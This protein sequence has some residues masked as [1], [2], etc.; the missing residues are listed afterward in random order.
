MNPGPNYEEI[1][2]EGSQCRGITGYDLGQ[3]QFSEGDA[4]AEVVCWVDLQGFN[5]CHA[6]TSCP[7]SSHTQVSCG[8]RNSQAW[9]N[10]DGVRCIIDATEVAIE[11]PP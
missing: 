5:R 8:G 7:N 3:C 11:C 4:S 9:S 10:V 6:N 2:S 1:E